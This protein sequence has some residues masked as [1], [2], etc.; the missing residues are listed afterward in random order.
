MKVQLTH[1]KDPSKVLATNFFTLDECLDLLHNK[2]TF[3]DLPFFEKLDKCS[4]PTNMQAYD[5][6]IKSFHIMDGRL[7]FSLDKF[8]ETRYGFRPSDYKRKGTM[9]IN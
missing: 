8:K 4:Y 1:H 9:E 6:L 5:A 7:L 3:R 2:K